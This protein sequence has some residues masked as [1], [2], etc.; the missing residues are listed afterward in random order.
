MAEK[1][2][3]AQI[4]AELKKIDERLCVTSKSDD[5]RGLLAYITIEV[6][7]IYYF[8]KM[9]LEYEAEQLWFADGKLCE[10]SD[11]I[12]AVMDRWDGVLR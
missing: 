1:L 2:S 10:L 7:D 5:I 9:S 3:T 12:L 6:G 8:W 4:E 11:K